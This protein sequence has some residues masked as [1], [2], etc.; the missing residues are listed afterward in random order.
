[1]MKLVTYDIGIDSNGP[2]RLRQIAKECLNYGVRVQNSVFEC[3]VTPAQW[4]LLK[5][6]LLSLY[7]SQYDSLRFYQLGANWRHKVEHFGCKKS[8][9]IYQSIIIV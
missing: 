9:D 4:E 5:N 3:E 8:I 6:K 2:Y 1:M 7:D